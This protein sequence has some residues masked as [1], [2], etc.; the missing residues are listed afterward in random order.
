MVE[1]KPRDPDRG[2]EDLLSDPGN[3]DLQEDGAE[4]DLRTDPG[5]QDLLRDPGVGETVRL[6]PMSSDTSAGDLRFGVSSARTGKLTP[7]TRRE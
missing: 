2:Q 5:V 4:R 3:R 7:T 6:G 1:P